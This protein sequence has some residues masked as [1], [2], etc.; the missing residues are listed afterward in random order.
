M[1]AAITETSALIRAAVCL[2]VVTLSAGCATPARISPG[3]ESI[4]QGTA[5]LAFS[6]NT[7]SLLTRETEIRPAQIEMRYGDKSVSID[8]SDKKSGIDRF[9]LEVPVTQISLDWFQ[10]VAGRGIFWSRYRTAFAHRTELALGEINYLG[11]LE[12]RNVNFDEY[13]DG[14][15]GIPVEVQLVFS[16]ALED[17]LSAW[18]EEYKLFQGRT[19]NHLVAGNWGGQDYLDLSYVSWSKARASNLQKTVDGTPYDPMRGPAPERAPR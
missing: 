6:V 1:V 5:V 12:I 13:A 3:Q 7:E 18:N 14:P 11:R 16:D 2:L 10:L 19:P 4:E 15:T 9:V 8:I 17:D